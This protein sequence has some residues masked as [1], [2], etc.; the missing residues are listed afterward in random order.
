ML[1]HCKGLTDRVSVVRRLVFASAT[2]P[3]ETPHYWDV[4][5]HFASNTGQVTPQ[6]AKTFIENVQFFDSDALSSD[7]KLRTDLLHEV[8]SN[9]IPLGLVLVSPKQSCQ[10]CSA[11]LVLKADRPSKVTIYTDSMGTIDGTH[12]RKICKQFRSGCPFV[13]HYGHYSTGVQMYF[14]DDWHTLPYFMSTRETAF[15]MSLLQQ[16]DAEVLIGQLSY[17]QRA[18]IYNIKHGCDHLFKQLAGKTVSTEQR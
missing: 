16:L 8:G 6:K 17:K 7:Q 11:P 12:Y 3:K 10:L 4:V 15:E 5:S 14:D 1:S 13:Q 2:L 18:E 9:G